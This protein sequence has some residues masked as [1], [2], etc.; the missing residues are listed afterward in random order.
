M[1]E[2]ATVVCWKGGKEEKFEMVIA[3][4]VEKNHSY[5]LNLL[6]ELAE[7][8]A[9][10]FSCIN[11]TATVSWQILLCSVLKTDS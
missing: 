10:Q 3:S 6:I 4:M 1:G 8:I 11:D 2:K 9:L 7:Q 5:V